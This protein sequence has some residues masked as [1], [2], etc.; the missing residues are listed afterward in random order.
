M[1]TLERLAL[2]GSPAIETS[3]SLLEPAHEHVYL[4]DRLQV[5]VALGYLPPPGEDLP[6]LVVLA[7]L[8]VGAPEGAIGHR[9]VGL[10]LDGAAQEVP[11]LGVLAGLEQLDAERVENHRVVLVPLEE[12]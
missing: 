4:P 9:V 6:S 5:P 7:E 8:E 11:R 1:E 10:V 12:L 2:G 3:G